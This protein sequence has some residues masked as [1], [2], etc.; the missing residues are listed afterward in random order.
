[1]EVLELHLSNISE[2]IPISKCSGFSFHSYI[3]G[4]HSYKQNWDPVLE[5]RYPCTTGEK[6]EHDEYDIV[7]VND[8]EVVGHFLLRL[9]KIMSMFLKLTGSHMEVEVT[10]KYVNRGAGYKLEIPCKCH[11]SG[12][13]KAV[14]WVSKKVNLIIKE[15]ECVVNICLDGK[16]K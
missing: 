4:F 3:R 1:M 12:Q 14:A 2:A 15:H 5:R 6:S 16:E 8:D 7:V 11:V 13:E 10:G 9:S